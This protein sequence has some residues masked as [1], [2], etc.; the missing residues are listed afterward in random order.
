MTAFLAA[1]LAALLIGGALFVV[2]REHRPWFVRAVVAS[3][4]GIGL[5]IV[6]IWWVMHGYRVVGDESSVA[7]LDL[8]VEEV[9]GSF[10]VSGNARNNSA[11]RTISAVPLTLLIDLCNSGTDASCEQERAISQTLTISIQPNESRPFSLVFSTPALP[12]H[13]HLRFRL[14]HQA[15]R[16]FEA[17]M[18]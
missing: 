17:V 10:R 4:T 8:R 1:T 5:V 14:A 16:S 7:L 11:E 13:D 6:Y 15:P 18:R 3:A 12:R 2:W 9:A